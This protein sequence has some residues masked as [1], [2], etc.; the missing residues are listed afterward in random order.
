MAGRCPPWRTLLRHFGVATEMNPQ[1]R[2]MTLKTALA[3]TFRSK[4]SRA[5]P[6]SAIPVQVGVATEE[7]PS[8]DAPRC[9][10]PLQF[11]SVPKP[12]SPLLAGHNLS[13]PIGVATEMISC[14]KPSRCKQPSPHL[15]RP[16]LTALLRATTTPVWCCHRNDFSLKSHDAENS[17]RHSRPRHTVRCVP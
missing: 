7:H 10:Q 15:C 2:F 6:R 11:R 14:E 4:P 3:I 17:P 12:A 9:K 1:R 8:P 16:S 13:K 5:E